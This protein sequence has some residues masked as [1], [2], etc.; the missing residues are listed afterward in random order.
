MIK[1]EL[2]W[3]VTPYRLVNIN[4]DLNI[5]KL[6][7]MYQ[8]YPRRLQYSICSVFVKPNCLITG[9]IKANSFTLCW[10]QRVKCATFHTPLLQETFEYYFLTFKSGSL[11][12][13]LPPLANRKVV[14]SFKA[15]ENLNTPSLLGSSL[16]LNPRVIEG[17]NGLFPWIYSPKLCRDFS[18]S[19]W[20]LCGPPIS[21]FLAQSP[22]L[23]T[24]TTEFRITLYV[25]W[26][27][28]AD[29]FF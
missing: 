14:N 24:R 23:T 10:V 5:I 6:V 19:P 26:T 28:S 13:P 20:M 29:T 16:N 25:S 9:F 12:F 11:N 7:N 17:L 2:F 21:F 27:L 18:L 15:N 8:S 22:T 3:D 4:T 1:T